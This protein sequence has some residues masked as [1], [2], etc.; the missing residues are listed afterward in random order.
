[1]LRSIRSMEART[2]RSVGAGR[3]AWAGPVESFRTGTSRVKAQRGGGGGF[4]FPPVQARA[5]S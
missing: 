4:G 1:M 3:S 2:S 5:I